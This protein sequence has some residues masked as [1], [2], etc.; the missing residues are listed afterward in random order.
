[1][2]ALDDLDTVVAY[3]ALDSPS[4]AGKLVDAIG[5]AATSLGEIPT[6]RRGRVAGTYEKSVT[7]LPYIIAYA[8]KA[9]PSGD[10]RVVILRVI[11]SA[12]DWPKGKWPK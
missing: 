10:E 8:L 6:G 12:R 3:I 5:R 1:L 11:H 9:L 7:R 4:A 2:A